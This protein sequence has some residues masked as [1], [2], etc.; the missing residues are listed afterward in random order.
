MEPIEV[1]MRINYIKKPSRRS[2]RE[3]SIFYITICYLRL[4]RPVC[5]MC[6]MYRPSMIVVVI[7]SMTTVMMVISMLIVMVIV[8]VAPVMMVM[9]NRGMMRNVTQRL[10]SGECHDS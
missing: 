10:R 6:V 1:S 4:N 2:N 3:G 8:P 7:P 9:M 5:R